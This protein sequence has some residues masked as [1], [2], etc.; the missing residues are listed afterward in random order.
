V[1]ALWGGILG[2]LPYSTNAATQTQ[3]AIQKTPLEISGWIPYWRKATGTQEAILHMST[4]K[5][6]NPFGYTVK[7]NGD[8]YDAM[9][10]DENPWPALVTAAR[11]KKVRVIPTVMWANTDAIHTVL[12]NPKT[13][14]AHIKGIVDMVKS[15]N[16]DGVDID[17][18]GKKAETRPYFSLFLKELY[19]AM[20]KKWVMC[21]IEARTPLDARYDTIPKNIEYANDYVAINKYCDR[22]R[23]MAYDQ[24]AIDLSLNRAGYGPYV[25]IADPLWVE[26]AIREAMKTITKKKIVIGI[27]TYGYEYEVKQLQ[28]GYRYSRLWS[29]NQNYATSLA[30]TLGIEPSRTRSGELALLYTPIATSTAT[31]TDQQD[32]SLSNNTTTAAATIVESTAI[33]TTTPLVPPRILWWGDAASIKDKVALA[34]KLGVRGVA[35]FKIDGGMDQ[36]MWNALK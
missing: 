19:A 18:E 21:T 23:I 29:F 32:Q 26:K 11:A 8:L 33:S 36:A 6:V 22:V 13:R 16:F 3:A 20:G 10:I 5:E 17:Y 9:K 2:L 31:S 27:P 24:G 14:K 4:F 15:H 28:Q 30:A 12:K 7:Q 35:I 34:K 25:P 1:F